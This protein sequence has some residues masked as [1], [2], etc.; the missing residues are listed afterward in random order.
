M[1]LRVSPLLGKYEF[2]GFNGYVGSAMDALQ[3][4]EKYLLTRP[5]RFPSLESGIEWQ[6]APRSLQS[7][8]SV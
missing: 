3:S 7:L 8:C 5:T 6:Y 4:M 1:L 2:S